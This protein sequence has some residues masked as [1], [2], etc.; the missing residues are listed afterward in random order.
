MQRTN[1]TRVTI[2]DVTS[3]C[4]D[5][6]HADAVMD[7]TVNKRLAKVCSISGIDNELKKWKGL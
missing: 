3:F 5:S 4:A 1:S 6:S 7:W 2:C